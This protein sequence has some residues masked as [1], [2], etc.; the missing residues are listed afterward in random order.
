MGNETIL[1]FNL[2][3]TEFIARVSAIEKPNAGDQLPLFFNLDKLHF[4]NADSG[5]AIR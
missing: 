5:N 3:G 1:Y 4:Y 2:G